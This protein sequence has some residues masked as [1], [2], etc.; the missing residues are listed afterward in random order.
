[1]ITRREWDK[2]GPWPEALRHWGSTEV[3]KGLQAHMT[4]T[5]MLAMKDAVVWH[6]FRNRFPYRTSP[7]G[8]MENAYVVA[9][10]MFGDEVF[11][12]TLLPVMRKASWGKNFEVLLKNPVLRHDVEEF[13]KRRVVDPAQFFPRFFPNGFPPPE[14]KK[15][16]GPPA[17]PPK[18]ASPAVAAPPVTLAV[19][20][21]VDKSRRMEVCKSCAIYDARRNRCRKCGCRMDIKTTLQREACPAGKW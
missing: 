5:P 1:M 19:A 21:P 13:A 20:S 16:A 12:K 4:G 3:C 17:T 11:Q 18:A 6:R 8:I 9:N 14:E 7:T 15:P 10:V 2:L